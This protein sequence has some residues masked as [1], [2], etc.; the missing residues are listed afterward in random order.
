MASIRLGTWNMRESVAVAGNEYAIAEIAETLDGLSLDVLVLQE[1]PFDKNCHSTEIDAITGHSDLRYHSTFPLSPSAFHDG[2]LSGLAVVS[3]TPLR[4]ISR[5]YLPNPLMQVDGDTGRIVSW[6]K[7]ML[8]V[9][10]GDGSS[11][12]YIASLH[13]FPF[14]MFR[15]DPADLEFDN[16]WKSLADGLDQIAGSALVAGDFNTDQLGLITTKLTKRS[17]QPLVKGA[18]GTLDDILCDADISLK[19]LRVKETFSDHPLLAAE[20]LVNSDLPWT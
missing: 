15:R 10:V 11:S 1:V 3:R 2:G 13:V 20:L 18:G 9:Q 12:L 14:R 7:G 19:N 8:L 5:T 6:D 17:M 16:I 4:V